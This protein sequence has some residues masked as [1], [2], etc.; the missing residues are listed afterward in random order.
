MKKLQLITL[1]S[2]L[3]ILASCGDD[4]NRR[5][6]QDI[7]IR[8]T[9]SGSSPYQGIVDA[10]GGAPRSEE[11]NTILSNIQSK[12]KE[13]YKILFLTDQPGGA[14]ALEIAEAFKNT[15]PWSV[16]NIETQII[17]KTSEEL[18][19]K[20]GT[21]IKRLI[22]AN[23]S[24]ASREA[25]RNNANQSMI[26]CNLPDG[27]AGGDIPIIAADH[28][29]VQVAFHEFMHTLGFSDEYAYS[30]DEAKIYCTDMADM[31]R[32]NIAHITPLASYTSDADA[33]TRHSSK[34][35]WYPHIIA[36]TLIT[37]GDQ[38]GTDFSKTNVFGL[39]EAGTCSNADPAIDLW[40]PE[41][42]TSIMQVTA[43]NTISGIYSTILFDILV[44]MG[45]P[46]RDLPPETTNTRV[47]EG[48]S[49]PASTSLPS[50]HTDS[51]SAL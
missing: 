5:Y 17:E 29:A 12:Q 18:N 8:R 22:T 9:E 45:V 26:V 41:S 39:F 20:E 40:K 51:G 4:E 48:T 49:A 36:S 23:R 24:L 1:S 31:T 10:F 27:G 46:L 43:G 35:P 21:V 15:R 16:F 3:I 30:A 7:P 14:K 2:L 33:R 32:V 13:R 6:G 42:G 37:H 38:L 25:S 34:I 19:C 28:R 11:L 50:T 47:H 44:D